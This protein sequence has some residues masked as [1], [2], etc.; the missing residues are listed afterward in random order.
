MAEDVDPGTVRLH[1]LSHQGLHI[2]HRAALHLAALRLLH[3]RHVMHLCD[4][5]RHL[6]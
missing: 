2:A 4:L 3:A 6:M 5:S 1:R